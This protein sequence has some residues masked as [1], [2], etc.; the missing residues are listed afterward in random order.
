[1]PS[2]YRCW[3][4]FLILS[5]SA[6]VDSS[7][8]DL[9]G[10][11]L[12]QNQIYEHTTDDLFASIPSASHPTSTVPYQLGQEN[13]ADLRLSEKSWPEPFIPSE[14]LPS[15]NRKLD[16]NGIAP[17]D[18]STGHGPLSPWP[19]SHHPPDGIGP[20]SDPHWLPSIGSTSRILPPN[21]DQVNQLSSGKRGRNRKPKRTVSVNQSA[22]K[23]R[24]LEE[25]L[26]GVSDLIQKHQSSETH[27]TYFTKQGS[28]FTPSL[29]KS[30]QIFQF[31]LDAAGDLHKTRRLYKKLHPGLPLVRIRFGREFEVLR[32]LRVG[33]DKVQLDRVIGLHYKNL[34]AFMHK[35]HE[36]ALELLKI[37]S[38]KQAQHQQEMLDWLCKECFDPAPSDPAKSPSLPITGP[39]RPPFIEWKGDCSDGS[40]GRTQQLLINYFSQPGDDFG[41]LPTTAFK[42]LEEFQKQHRTDGHGVIESRLSESPPIT[43]QV[44][45]GPIQVGSMPRVYHT[46]VRLLMKLVADTEIYSNPRGVFV[47]RNDPNPELIPSLLTIFGDQC[48]RTKPQQ[49]LVKSYHRLFAIATYTSE[50]LQSGKPRQTIRVVRQNDLFPLNFVELMPRLTRLM[51]ALDIFHTR[52]LDHLKDLKIEVVNPQIR[53][54]E[55]L[56]WLIQS[57]LKPTNSLPIHGPFPTQVEHLPWDKLSKKA[58]RKLFGQVQ[59]ELIDYFSRNDR[60]IRSLKKKVAFL[61]A[62][63]YQHIYPLE[64]EALLQHATEKIVS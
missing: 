16:E 40:V 42:L 41:L 58:S 32:V 56:E 24:K 13:Q 38:T 37:P 57:I 30:K 17:M 43:S 5:I 64:F 18:T 29:K 49:L 15:L 33:T 36:D 2:R 59:Q 9:S 39:I 12:D 44:E 55:L 21:D 31:K 1:M 6:N 26:S 27:H 60:R 8:P 48:D 46:S 10:G 35:L 63:W 53:R 54:K 25:R 4:G 7:F 23:L 52:I 20:F 28:M 47:I 14:L 34:I 45:E 62:S 3:F 19:T 22:S 51:T 50:H 11:L 61:T